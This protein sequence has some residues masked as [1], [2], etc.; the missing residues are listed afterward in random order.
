MRF[1]H[2]LNGRRI[3]LLIRDGKANTWPDLCR[4]CGLNPNEFHTGHSI[5]WRELESLRAAGLIDFKDKRHGSWG[6][7]TIQG[8]VN[9]TD[10]WEG[11]Q[12]ALGISLAQIADFD[13]DDD[14]VVTP[15]WGQPGDVSQKHDVFV[16]MPF[17]DALRPVYEDH[18]KRVTSGL[19]L[20][21]GRA[22]DLFSAH[23]VMTDVWSGIF[24]ARL[25]I[26]DCTGRNPNVFYEI[27]L[28]HVLGRPVVLI[29]QSPDDV[30]F[31][32]K[33]IRFIHYIF[34]P[35]GMADFEVALGET[36]R[37]VLDM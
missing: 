29:T 36:I 24:N 5:L 4:A 33:H 32:V 26:A 9:V 15:F 37:N 23:S 35:R 11:I 25:I 20:T 21:I 12:S 7:R 6:E 13:P 31:D 18:I 22:D 2:N 27:G 17:A 16:L 30:P 14:L 8:K 1:R 10:S 34:T 28:C 19:S 3:L